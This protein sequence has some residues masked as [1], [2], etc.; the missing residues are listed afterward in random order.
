MANYIKEIRALVGHK[1]IILNTAAG[2][3]VN[4]QQQVLL[5]LRT[6]RR[7]PR[8]ACGNIRKIVAMMSKLLIASASLIKAR[9]PI[10]TAM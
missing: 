7:M 6:V 10:L 8:P 9:R 5:N 4:D 2:I 3:L 1:P